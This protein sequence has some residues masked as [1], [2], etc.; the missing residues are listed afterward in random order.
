MKNKARLFGLYLPVFIIILIA[1]V[2]LRSVLILN[3]YKEG[4][5]TNK[6]IETVSNSM[7]IF[8]S[9]CFLTYIWTARKGIKLIPS[10][11]SPAN[12][13]PSAAVG[14][15]L[16]ALIIHFVPLAKQ[17][18]ESEKM[19][20]YEKIFTVLVP[21]FAALSIVYFIFNTIYI[22]TVSVK[23]ANLGIFLLIF[24]CL[25]MAY[26]YFDGTLAMNSP[27]KTADELAYLFAAVFFL[28]ETRLSLGREKWKPYIAFGF[29]ASLLSAYS[30]IPSLIAYI[31]E[32]ET[33]S[34][35]IY[36]SVL[37]FAI[38]LFITCKLL[39]TGELIEKVESPTVSGLKAYAEQRKNDIEARAALDVPDE[40]AS[41]AQETD[42]NQISILDISDSEDT[43]DNAE[44]EK[45]AETEKE[46]SPE[47]ETTS[48]GFET[49]QSG[50]KI[51]VEE[52]DSANEKDSRD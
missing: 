27:I 42:E 23:R 28:Y 36:E 39:L 43:K 21:I 16:L 41:Q 32:G 45:D 11:S 20:I 52:K 26:I 40:S 34:T 46:T 12:F 19:P 18:L 38:F 13:V 1:A 30:S 17:A 50:E 51:T 10:F 4:Y 47:E 35:S 7:V 37:T 29:I 24:L 3:F 44:A 2:A 14:A 22:R 5:F 15:A 6:T 31:V 49:E 8:G 33:I 48:E 9:V 25:F